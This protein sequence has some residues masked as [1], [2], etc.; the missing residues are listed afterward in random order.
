MLEQE[1]QYYLDHQ[2]EIV[3]K[4]QGKFIIIKNQEIVGAYDSKLE[5]YQGGISKYEPG[6][7]LIQRCSEGNTDYIQTFHSRVAFA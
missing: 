3:Q 7:F 5:A 1:F 2:D 4:Y 6:T